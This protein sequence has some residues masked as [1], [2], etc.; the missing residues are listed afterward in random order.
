MSEHDPPDKG[1]YPRGSDEFSRAINFNDAVFAIALTLLSVSLAVPAL[2][3]GASADELWSRLNDMSSELVSFVISFAVIGRYW[4]AH[5]QFVSRLGAIDNGLI[6]IN[7]VYLAFV[8]FLPFP[9]EMLGTHFEN[10][11][12]VTVYA[13]NVALIS[14]FEVLLLA[15]AQRQHLFARRVPGDVYRWARLMSLTPV[16][17]FIASIPVAYVDTTA[18]ALMWLLGLPLGIWGERH[19][20]AHTDEYF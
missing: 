11:A 12:A 19:K 2:T 14:G 15:R 6:G 10:P 17:T 9:T 1:R 8:A 4:F 18:A 7:L 20:P 5:H 16:F 13:V 3:N